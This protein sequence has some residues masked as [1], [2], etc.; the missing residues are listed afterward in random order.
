MLFYAIWASIETLWITWKFLLNKS[1]HQKCSIMSICN[2][3]K[4]VFFTLG[5]W[6]T[7]FK[8]TS[9]NF[10]VVWKWNAMVPLYSPSIEHVNFNLWKWNFDRFCTIDFSILS[11]NCSHVCII[12]VKIY[13][14][15]SSGGLEVSFS[16][17]NFP[18]IYV[19][20]FQLL[21]FTKYIHILY[22]QQ[23]HKLM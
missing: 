20:K 11:V 5:P 8:A 10:S 17:V 19:I 7:R 15:I 16:I 18:L 3:I 4:M 14:K 13:E 1:E 9:S 22:L 21:H 6:N 2:T 23:M 12:Y